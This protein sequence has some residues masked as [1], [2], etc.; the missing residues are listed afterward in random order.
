MAADS[1]DAIKRLDQVM[2]QRSDEF[3]SLRAQAAQSTGI[4]Q[5]TLERKAL[6]VADLIG[7]LQVHQDDLAAQAALYGSGVESFQQ[8]TPPLSP[9]GPAPLL[10]A[11]AGAVVGLLAASGWAWWAAGRYRRVEAGG[12][13]GTILG[14]PLLGETPRLGANLRG[15]GGPSSPPD[16]V[17][18]VAAESY[19]FVLASLEHALQRTGGKVV[20]VASARPG[21]GKTVTVLNLALAA[22]REGRKVLLIDADERTRRLSELCRDNAHFDVIGV[23]R[24]GEECPAVTA[25][26]VLEVGPSQRNGDHPAVFFRSTTFGKLISLSGE[27]ADLVLIDTPALLDVSEAVTIADHADAILL[28]VNRGSS[29]AELRRA[30]ERLVFTDTPLAGY[31]LNRGY[32]RRAYPGNGSTGR[33]SR[34]RGLLR[35]RGAGEHPHPAPAG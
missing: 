13:A 32:A 11:L 10:L 5:S 12:D 24:E 8:A 27:P 34:G 31:L 4:N 19:H 3:D 25:G 18:P 35:R 20:A 33:P 26:S 7:A 28:V 14:V 2:A 21:D 22:R 9:S 29:L 17:D 16:E 6:H 23:S 30:R 1:K 15:T